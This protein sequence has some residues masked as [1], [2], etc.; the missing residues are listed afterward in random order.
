[1]KTEEVYKKIWAAE[2]GTLRTPRLFWFRG[3]FFGKLW[4]IFNFT[5]DSRRY[6]YYDAGGSNKKVK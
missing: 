6:N 5:I 1:M 2:F 4:N 3:F